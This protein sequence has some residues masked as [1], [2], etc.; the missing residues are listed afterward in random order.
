[1]ACSIVTFWDREQR[2]IHARF[3]QWLCSWIVVMCAYV[4]TNGTFPFP[5]GHAEADRSAKC[6]PLAAKRARPGGNHACFQ[7]WTTTRADDCL[8]CV[9]WAGRVTK[10]VARAP[11]RRTPFRRRAALSLYSNNRIISGVSTALGPRG[12]TFLRVAPW[13]NLPGAG[14]S[15]VN[16]PM[17]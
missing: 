15:R 3:L 12:E 11:S 5:C 14:N 8:R 16:S 17:A 2:C 9:H 1:M 6:P 13:W 7:Y 4:Q 10:S